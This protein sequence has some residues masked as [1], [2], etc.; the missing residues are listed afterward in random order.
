MARFYRDCRNPQVE[1]LARACCSHWG[2]DPD[3]QVQE[4]GYDET[5]IPRW[6]R[7]Q[8]EAFNFLAMM[9]ALPDLPPVTDQ[10]EAPTSDRT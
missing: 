10:A 8:T 2:Y 6:W 5:T 9:A 1:H 3:E 4:T 7:Y